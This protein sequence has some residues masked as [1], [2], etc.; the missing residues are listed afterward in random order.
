MFKMKIFQSYDYGCK[1][2]N[3]LA[4]GQEEPID[5]L[6]KYDLIDI[7]M[8]LFISLN[9]DLIKADDILEHYHALKR[10]RPDLAH[11]KIYEGYS[12]I[13]FTYQSHHALT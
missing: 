9:D 7:D 3:L 8:H 12:H 5:Y 13:D 10:H 11:L 1:K 2:Q 6:G 4:N